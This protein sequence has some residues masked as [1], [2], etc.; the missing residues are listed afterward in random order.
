MVEEV[1]EFADGVGAF[2][3]VDREG[4]LLGG[5]GC[6]E[7]LHEGG[8]HGT[9][10]D[11]DDCADCRGELCFDEFVGISH[12]ALGEVIEGSCRSEVARV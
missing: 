6:G 10:A 1:A 7:G 12:Q 5:E 3:N 4:S 8:V 2:E 11:A 9:V